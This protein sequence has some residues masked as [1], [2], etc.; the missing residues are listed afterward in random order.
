MDE[1]DG[2]SVNLGN[3]RPQQESNSQ[4]GPSPLQ[5]AQQ[6]A[7]QHVQQ[8]AQ[9]AAH[10]AATSAGRSVRQ[11]LT[12]IH[13]YIQANPTSVTVLSFVGGLVL[14]VVSVIGLLSILGPLSGPFAY[15]LQFYEVIFGLTICAIDGPGDKLP[16]L[17]QLVLTH[18]A[19]LHNNTSRALFYLFVT[20]LE[21]TQES[22]VHKV[23]GYYFLAIS[24]AFAILRIMNTDGSRGAREPLAQPN[25]A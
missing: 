12:E 16:R 5:Q 1:S 3:P 19:F 2:R 4:G 21:A 7:Q 14:A 22:W 8:A 23:V 9:Q 13:V 15:V 10:Q 18:A 24:V 11:G 20:C 17:R 6:Q 25:S